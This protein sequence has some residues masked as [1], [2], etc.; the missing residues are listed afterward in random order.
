MRRMGWT[1]YNLGDLNSCLARFEINNPARI[2]H[3]ISQC[4][5]ES[6]NGRWTREIANGWAYEGRRDLG[7]TQP[8][9]GP[10]FKGAGYLQLTGRAN[11]QNFANYIQD[12]GVMQGVDY[13]ADRYPWTCSGYWWMRNGMNGLCDSGASVE[14]VT[15]R[16]NGGYNDL[17]DR[18]AKYN[19]A[20]TIF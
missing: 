14:Q 17:E 16:V 5:H 7:N 19:L 15:R 13:V 2:R 10:R 18:R 8:G 1:N 11:Y 9:D 4:S 20:C 3:F 12:Q 6:G